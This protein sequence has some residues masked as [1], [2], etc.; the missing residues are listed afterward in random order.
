MAHHGIMVQLARKKSACY[1][2][3]CTLD[4]GSANCFWNRLGKVSGFASHMVS[5]ATAQIHSCGV[6]TVPGN[7]KSHTHSCVPTALFIKTSGMWPAGC[8][9]PIP[10]GNVSKSCVKKDKD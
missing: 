10:A 7:S 3:M 9:V 4:P 8:G 1:H 6:K 5:V 2:T